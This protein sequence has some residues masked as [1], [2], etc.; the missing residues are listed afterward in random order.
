MVRPLWLGRRVLFP[1][2]AGDPSSDR[3]SRRY[4]AHGLSLVLAGDPRRL[5]PVDLRAGVAGNQRRCA[6]GASPGLAAALF[7]AGVGGGRGF[8]GVVLRLRAKAGETA[9]A[10]PFSPA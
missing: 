9:V 6:P 7:R 8:G 2:A 1:I 3:H 10:E 5:A 4:S